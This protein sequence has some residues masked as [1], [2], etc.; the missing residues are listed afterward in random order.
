M[1]RRFLSLAA[2]LA[3][4]LQLFLPS[5]IWHEC[6]SSAK[7]MHDCDCA[8]AQD[9]DARSHAAPAGWVT[10]RCCKVRVSEA[11]RPIVLRDKAVRWSP[12]D[13]LV[14]IARPS[15]DSNVEA[16]RSTAA[17]SLSSE[18]RAKTPLYLAVRH[19]LI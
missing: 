5:A 2:S 10:Q 15:P 6:R 4:G 11:A 17:P 19:L 12:P 18:A 9:L 14:A 1:I 8:D 16:W 7:A 3:F 13:S